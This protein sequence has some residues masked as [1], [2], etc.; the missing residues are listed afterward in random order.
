MSSLNQYIADRFT[1]LT[2][3]R[4]AAGAFGILLLIVFVWPHAHLVTEWVVVTAIPGAIG[5]IVFGLTFW[6][7]ARVQIGRR[8]LRY[9]AV[10]RIAGIVAL[11]GLP[12]LLMQRASTYLRSPREAVNEALEAYPNPN[13]WRIRVVVAIA[14]LEGD[15]GQQLEGRLRDALDGLDRRLHI[16]P[17]ILNRTIAVSGRSQAISHRDARES[18][19]HVRVDAL[20]WGGAKGAAHPAVGPLYETRFGTYPQFGGV[21]LPA[22]FKLPELPVDDLCTVLRLMI[23]TQSAYE[24]V[25][26]GFKFGDALEPLIK[27]VRAM[28]DDPHKTSGWTADTRARVNLIVGIAGVPS[29]IEL[30]SADSFN[31]AVDYC[32][33]A[34]ASWTR[35]RDPLEWA[36][37]QMNLG[38]ALRGQADQNVE[39]APLQAAA[40]A[41]KEALAVYQ[42]QS[43]RLDSAQA[44]VDLGGTFEQMAAHEAGADNLRQAV[45]YYRAAVNGFDVRYYAISSA[46]AQTRLGAALSALA[47]REG[48][49]KDY[50]DAIAAF[51]EA[52]KVYHKQTEPLRWASTQAQLAESLQLLGQARSNVDDLKESVAISRQLLDG[53]PRDH[54]P[55]GWAATEAALGNELATLNDIQPDPAYAQQAVVALRASL[56][57]LSLEHEPIAWATAEEALGNALMSL[58]ETGTDTFYFE[59]AIEA[60]NEA[61]KVFRPDR[62]PVSW[63]RT[64]S[65]LGDALSDLGARGAGIKHLEEAV[66][67]YR[68][69]LTVL[70]KDKLPD[71]WKKTQHNLEIT[72]EELK[73]RG[74]KGS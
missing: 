33:R 65:D 63:A 68:E 67:N 54:D 9:K 43:D 13:G 62:D 49:P 47:D 39:V 58:G 51:R 42:A 3:A 55:R 53:Y 24:L 70:T 5:A 48:N 38:T 7:R 2:R 29:G 69:A 22:D 56:E 46:E 60:F 59:Q 66:S 35:D 21:Y 44:Q 61:L 11:V 25:R 31:T 41:F 23:A 27:Q 52:L 36:M 8:Q 20:I 26:W 71:D 12:F 72:L 4:A 45:D 15:N 32:R 17:V 57:E 73:E 74:W 37:A 16:T 14:H 19:M 6:S 50:Q 28:A 10:R 1:W 30:K 18:V 34:L 40:T 64:K